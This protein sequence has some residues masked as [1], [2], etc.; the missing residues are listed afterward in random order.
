MRLRP[1]WMGSLA[2]LCILTGAAFADVTVSHSNQPAADLSGSLSALF[3]QE[4]AALGS[5]S[6]EQLGVVARLPERKAR[7]KGMAP[8]VPLVDEAYLAGLPV[9]TGDGEWECLAKAIYFEA[10]GEDITGQIA[11]AEVILNRTESPLYPRT[12]CRVVH[13]GGAGGC[14]FS[15]TCDGHSDAIRERSAFQIAGKIA[16][17]MLDGQPRTLTGGATHFHTVNVR[18]GWSRQFPRTAAIGTHYFYRASTGG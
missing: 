8:S 12:I 1:I 3:G 6:P 13:Q 14:Q 2:G 18:P 10:R 17:L 15:F 9:A 16:R 5:V 7:G 4:R 11:V